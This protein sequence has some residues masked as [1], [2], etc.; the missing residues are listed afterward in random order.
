M[1]V[2]ILGE[3]QFLMPDDAITRLNELDAELGLAGHVSFTGPQPR[4]Q[5]AGLLRGAKAVL[6][7]SHSETFGLLALEA[8]ASGTP[9]IASAAGGLREAVVDGDLRAFG[10]AN[11]FV[12]STAVL[13][14][15]GQANPTLTA[16]ELGLRL[17]D[18]ILEGRV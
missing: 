14:T 17:A 16:V 4:E 8:A 2:R 7:P 13:P 18:A 3:G 1:I 11:L 10:T 12:A 5:L 9:V 6:V 15:S